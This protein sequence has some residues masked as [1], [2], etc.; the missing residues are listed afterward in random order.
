MPGGSGFIP[1]QLGLGQDLIRG[2]GGLLDSLAAR[3]FD[4]VVSD[5]AGYHRENNGGGQ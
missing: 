4:P 5:R 2:L 1:E 3:G